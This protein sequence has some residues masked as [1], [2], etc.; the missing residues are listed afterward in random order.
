MPIADHQ[1]L[2]HLRQ[3]GSRC[4]LE[5]VRDE[6]ARQ[7]LQAGCVTTTQPQLHSSTAMGWRAGVASLLSQGCPSESQ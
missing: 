3:P 4:Q 7:Q 6:R 5:H 1:S 2:V